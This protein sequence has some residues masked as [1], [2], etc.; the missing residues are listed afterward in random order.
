[1]TA[2]VI[3]ALVGFM[4]GGPFGAILGA[5]VGSWINRTYLGGRGAAGFG[6]SAASRQ[7]AQTAFFRATFLVMGRVAKADGRVSEYEIETA[8]AIMHNMRLSEDQRRMAIDLFNEG[9]KPSSDIEGALRAFRE[10]AGA[11]TLIPM[12]LEIQLSAA[13]ADGGLSPAEQAVFKQV[14]SILGVGNFAFDQIHKRFIAQREY[15]QQGGYHSGPGGSSRASS[16]MDLKRAYDVLGVSESASDTEV[17]KAYRKL[18][19]EH[20][21][22]K[23]VA[24]GLPEEMMEVAKEKTQEIQGAY[25][26]VRAARK[27]G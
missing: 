20:H 10:V 22:D 5:F 23:L 2:I 6:A 19:S 26:Q 8:R 18:M 9:K 11:S 14:C 21:P 16:G 15:Y 17:K 3:G 27:K 4:T 13:Y 1:M 12:F 24:K 25:D 7:K